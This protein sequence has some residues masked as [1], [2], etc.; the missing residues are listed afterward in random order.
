[1]A[2]IIGS[3]ISRCSSIGSKL[4]SSLSALFAAGGSE[5]PQFMILGLDGAGKTM[6]MYRLK[7]P[8]WPKDD[9]SKTLKKIKEKEPSSKKDDGDKGDEEGGPCDW[10]YHYE[11]IG[12]PFDMGLWDMPG[13]VAM[14]HVWPSIYQSIKVHGVIFVVNCEDAWDPNFDDKNAELNKKDEKM[15]KEK[16]AA[17]DVAQQ[18][19][20]LSRKYLHMLMNEDDLRQAAFCV[21]VNQRTSREKDDR[22]NAKPLYDALNEDRLEYMLGLHD[23]HPSCAWRTKKFVMNIMNINGESDRNWI[24]MMEW[25]RTVISDPKGLGMKIG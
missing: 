10:G 11:E 18:R 6:L 4:S 21:V 16:K 23:L 17:N 22:G 8:G 13:T 3:L 2:A 14:R 24:G 9:M 12:K 7:I 25:A 1:M 5:D 20:A 19:V 15:F